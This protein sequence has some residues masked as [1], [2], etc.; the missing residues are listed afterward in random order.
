MHF[1]NE[2]EALGS[3]PF[4]EPWIID[5]DGSPAYTKAIPG[6]S[7]CITRSRYRGHWLTS[8]GRRMN[9]QETLRLQGFDDCFE[10]PVSERQLRLMLGN[11]MSLNVLERF[12][13]QLIAC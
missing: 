7:P 8:M 5:C 2:I 12:L 3:D 11:G 6:V 9:L 13:L 10:N 4:Y 1:L